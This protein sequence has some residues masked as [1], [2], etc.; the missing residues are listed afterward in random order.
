M[1]AFEGVSFSYPGAPRPA[2]EDINLTLSPGEFMVVMG[3]NGS[4]KSTLVRLANGLL[5]PT[6]G[7]VVVEGLDTRAEDQL[8][9][10]RPLV[11]MVFQDPD[12]QLV[13][14]TVEEDVA[15]G[16]ENLGL[17]REVIRERVER[18]LSTLGLTELRQRPPHRL[19]GGQKQRAAL[20]GILAMEPRYIL[21]DEAT[22][23]LDPGSREEVWGLLSFLCREK[24]LGIMLVSHQPEE[25]VLADKVVLLHEGRILQEGEPREI[26]SRPEELKPLG[27]EAPAATVLA[28]RLARRGLPLPPGLLTPGEV[29]RALRDLAGKGPSAPRKKAGRGRRG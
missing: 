11:G 10:I 12:N 19:S 23:M 7:R 15:F 28:G 2:L 8:P 25:A 3:P 9:R 16:P 18:A 17:P 13:A 29:A 1:L 20:A 14:A 27:L 26:F 5:R 4:G 22:A 6:K 21:L 24:G